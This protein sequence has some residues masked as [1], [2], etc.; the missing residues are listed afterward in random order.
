MGGGRER[1]EFFFFFPGEFRFFSLSCLSL[2]FVSLS[3]HQK[4]K[5]ILTEERRGDRAER[6]AHVHPV[7]ERA[8]VGEEG[9]GLGAAERGHGVG[10]CSRRKRTKRRSRAASEGVVFFYGSLFFCVALKTKRKLFL[11]FAYSRILTRYLS[12]EYTSEKRGKG[13]GVS[14]GG[15]RKRGLANRERNKWRIGICRRR[16]S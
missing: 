16:E 14:K 9:L 12:S 7:Q 2:P 11:L 15:R 1:R 6:H 10:F 5:T 13:K 4:K 3:P 8:L